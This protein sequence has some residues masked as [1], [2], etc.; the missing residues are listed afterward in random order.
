[1]LNAELLYVKTDLKKSYTLG[2]R[3]SPEMLP[4][5]VLTSV[6]SVN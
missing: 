5:G 2:C 1:M 3:T 6:F 4:D